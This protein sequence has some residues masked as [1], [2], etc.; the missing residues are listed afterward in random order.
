[1]TARGRDR[2]CRT[3]PASRQAMTAPLTF[4]SWLKRR[5]QGLGLTQKELRAPG[6]LR[7]GHAAQGGSRRTAAFGANGEEVWRRHWH[8]R[9]RNKP[10][11]CA[12][13]A[14]KP[15]W[16]DLTLPGRAASPPIPSKHVPELADSAMEDIPAQPAMAAVGHS[17]PRHN[18]PALTTALIGRNEEL[19][20]L[21][22]LLASPA[23]RNGHD[24]QRRGDGQD[25]PGSCGSQAAN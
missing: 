21:A 4:G 12:L 1:M 18:L 11:S 9:R 7:P 8:S 17:K 19:A 2:R 3:P 23:T 6:G 22:Q 5:R 20:E 16:D 14:M 10:S 25:Q 15:I 24:P 13:P